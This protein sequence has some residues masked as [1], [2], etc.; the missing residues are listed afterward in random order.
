[1]VRLEDLPH[2]GEVTAV[3]IRDRHTAGLTTFL[4]DLTPVI[5]SSSRIP[6]SKVVGGRQIRA[7][8]PFLLVHSLV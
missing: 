7:A 5:P 4:P 6:A 3:D 1:M 2:P 8:D